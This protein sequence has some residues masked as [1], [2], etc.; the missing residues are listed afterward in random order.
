[1]I[2]SII[3]VNW[4]TID[5]L[6]ECLESIFQNQPK[7]SFEVMV[8]DNASTDGSCE[9]V[10][11][12]FPSTILIENTENKGFAA[13]NNQGFDIA[14]GEYVL[15]LNSDTVVHGNVLEECVSVMKS[16]PEMGVL[17]CRVLNSDGSIQASTSTFPGLGSLLLLLLGIN[18]NRLARL[19]SK[20]SLGESLKHSQR[21]V[22][23]ISGCFMM[24]RATA[25][26]S[27]GPLDEDFFFF[28]EE[29]DWCMRF[30]G[31]GWQLV[32]SPVGTITHYGGGSSKPL[33]FKRDLL[34]SE[35]TVR[36]NIKHKSLVTGYVAY[37]LLFLFNV[38]R[39]LLWKILALLTRKAK[40]RDRAKYFEGIVF[41]FKDAWPDTRKKNHS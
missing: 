40:S 13:A 3:I 5:L 20:F 1:M 2:L 31:R 19:L 14:K 22:Q 23:V 26:R 15:L 33:N 39:L 17:G 30:R 9:M 41:N 6:Q 8:I 29:T 12:K 21:F 7:V 35:A 36:L 11:K 10:R 38:S 24:V 34:L 4:N 25:L 27:V 16:D 18:R 32:Y 37:A 28:G